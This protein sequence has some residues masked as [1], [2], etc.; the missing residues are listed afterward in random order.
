MKIDNFKFKQG[1]IYTIAEIGKNHNGDI[2]KAKKMIELA[3]YEG[4]H[5]VKF[6][7]YHTD[8]LMH[9]YSESGAEPDLEWLRQ[10]ELQPVDLMD[11]K[12]LCDNLGITFLATPESEVW[13]D[14]LA[15]S[16]HVSAF[17]ASSLNINNFRML[18]KIAEKITKLESMPN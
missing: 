2:N 8:H 10:C 4:C 6:Q 11:M 18:D 13:V 15:N 9:T 3:Y 7:A 5:A 17:K 16:L 14:V 1:Q 12:K